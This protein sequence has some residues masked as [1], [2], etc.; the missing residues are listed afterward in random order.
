MAFGVVMFGME[1][2]IQKDGIIRIFAQKLLCFR[3]VISHIYEIALKT[4]REPSMSSLII[5]QKKNSNWMALRFHFAQSE[6]GQQ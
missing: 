4:S 2:V 5:V 3:H 1:I 6:F